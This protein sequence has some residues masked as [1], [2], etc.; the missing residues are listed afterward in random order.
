MFEMFN[1]ALK[2]LSDALKK[3]KV[4]SI[5]VSFLF[6]GIFLFSYVIFASAHIST[7]LSTLLAN[8][9][10]AVSGIVYMK[11]TNLVRYSM[12][13]K[14]IG[15]GGY[16]GIFTLLAFIWLFSQITSYYLSVLF[17]PDVYKTYSNV[18]QENIIIYF[19]LTVV[20]API[21]EEIMMRGVVFGVL[22]KAY[23]VYVAYI[24]SSIAFGVVHGTAAHIVV[25]S[26]CGLF[27]SFVY[28]Y[29]G[30]IV[31]SIFVHM[32]YNFACLTATQLQ[33]PTFFMQPSVFIFFDILIIVA[34]IVWS[35]HV[36][37]LQTKG[38]RY[39]NDKY[40]MEYM[41]HAK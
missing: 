9:A 4:R 38:P 19:L 1:N 8:V 29:T 23:P 34:L 31:A 41:R 37:R 30:N 12:S 18:A 17:D 22:Q 25:G 11:S 5:F 3:P 2:D 35:V 33:I 10:V 26:M 13:P 36:N 7:G 14:A 39:F 24:V 21:G 6:V 32:V 16:F 15:I 20:F 27:F 28:Q 40:V